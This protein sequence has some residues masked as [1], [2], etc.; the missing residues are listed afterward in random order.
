[1]AR[2]E[3]RKNVRRSTDFSAAADRM[4]V[5]WGRLATPLVFFLSIF[6]SLA[7]LEQDQLG[8]V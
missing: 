6:T 7:I 8:T 5:R 2:P 3:P 1:M 4:L